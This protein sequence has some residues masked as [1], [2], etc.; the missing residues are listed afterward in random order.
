MRLLCVSQDGNRHACEV[1]LTEDEL[2]EIVAG[3]QAALKKLDTIK[4]MVADLPNKVSSG[5]R[6]Q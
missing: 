3:G 1:A 6:E 2:K 4:A 5:G